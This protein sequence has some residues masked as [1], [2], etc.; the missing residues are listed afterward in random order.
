MAK[1]G[2]QPNCH[3]IILLLAGT[4]LK[5][6]E[7]INLLSNFLLSSSCLR[8]CRLGTESCGKHNEAVAITQHKGKC[9]QDRTGQDR[10]GQDR[11]GQDRTGQ[12]RTGQDRT[13]QDRTGQDRTGQDRTG[14]DR[15]GPDRTGQ[16][17][18]L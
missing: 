6:S 12:D 8:G 1:E 11:T 16:D 4:Q 5:F 14:Q 3:V 15:T 9:G 17:R 13:G 10:T 18:S 7:Q 2:Y